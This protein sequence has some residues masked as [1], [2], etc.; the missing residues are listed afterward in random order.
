MFLLNN[1]PGVL[2]PQPDTFISLLVV[3]DKD[4][5][6]IL[7]EGLLSLA[8]LGLFFL[9]RHNTSL[10]VLTPVFLFTFLPFTQDGFTLFLW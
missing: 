7:R 2:L 4:D 8:V 3:F 9:R 10:R 1:G 5:H 6:D